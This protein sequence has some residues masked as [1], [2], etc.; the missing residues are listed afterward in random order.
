[1]VRKL[2]E[3]ASSPC[4]L[5]AMM[6]WMAPSRHRCAKVGFQTTPTTGAIH[7]RGYNDRSG[8]GQ[9]RVSGA[10]GRSCRHGCR[11]ARVAA[12]AGA[13]VV[14]QGATVPGGNGSVR[15]GSL[16]GARAAPAGP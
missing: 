16:L 5:L 1:M 3:I 8:F 10:R 11:A 15:H 9:E 13:G 4:V 7:E 6:G 2:D 14:C 12:L